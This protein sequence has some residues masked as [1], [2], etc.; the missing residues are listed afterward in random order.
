MAQPMTPV[1]PK[2]G[3]SLGIGTTRAPL[4]QFGG[5]LLPPLRP[6]PV[7]GQLPAPTP[8]DGPTELPYSPRNGPRAAGLGWPPSS[9]G[10]L[11][12]VAT[13]PPDDHLRPRRH[14]GRVVTVP[15]QQPSSPFRLANRRMLLRGHSKAPYR[16][17]RHKKEPQRAWHSLRGGP[18][19]SETCKR[20]WI[21]WTPKSGD[22]SCHSDSI[23]WILHHHRVYVSSV[24]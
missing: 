3:F 21:G 8:I 24:L 16:S 4:Q 20:W 10:V 22:L 12:F 11:A 7:D 1:E 6:P 19:T 15:S 13:A 17:A 2:R 23:Q 18:R 5:L 14:P 9:H